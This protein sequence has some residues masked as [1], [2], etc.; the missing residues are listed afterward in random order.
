MKPLNENSSI[1][2]NNVNNITYQ[3]TQAQGG[4]FIYNNVA[5]IQKEA[6]ELR[7]RYSSESSGFGFGVSAGVGSNGQIKPNSISG[8]ISINGGNQNTA[9]TVY[10]NGNFNNVNE[11]HNNT[12]S[13]TLS[14]FNQEG[15]KVT[16]N[17]GKL[18]VESRQNTSTTTGSSSGISLGISANG[19]PNS[20]NV[21]GSR[22]NGSRAFVDN[23]SS[24]V[25][26]EGSNLHVG[27]LENTGAVIGKQSDNSTTF[28]IDNYVGK[29]IQNYDTMTTTG[30][31]MGVSLGGKPRITSVGFNQDNR[32]KEG[33]TRNT[34]V[35]NVEIQNASG[36]EINRDLGKANEITKDTHRSINVNV[37]PQVIEYISNPTK[38]KEDLEVAILEGK[39]TGETVLKSIENAVNGR[40]SS[41]IGDPERRTINEIKESIIRVKTAPE[42]N[43]IATGDLNSE[44]ILKEL[45]ISAV[46]K[47]DPDN[48]NLPPKVR[49]RVDKLAQKGEVPGIFYDKITNKI[50]VDENITDEAVIRA[51]IAREWKISE[52]LKTGKG[53]EN[54]EG[55]LK[56]TVAGELAYDDMMK[57]AREGKTGSIST[58]ELGVAVMDVNSEV[59]A[60]NVLDW[61][62]A[63]YKKRKEDLG[64]FAAGVKKDLKKLKAETGYQ[65]RKAGNNAI[66]LKEQYW[67][68][69]PK[70]ANETR[71]KIRADRSA[72]TKKKKQYDAQARE[73]KAKS[74]GRKRQIDRNL[75]AKEEKDRQKIK[76]KEQKKLAEKKRKEEQLKREQEEIAKRS[77]KQH[78][79]TRVVSEQEKEYI[80]YVLKNKDKASIF[81]GYN[82]Q[83]IGK[84]GNNYIIKETSKPIFRKDLPQQY[85][86]MDFKYPALSEIRKE[87]YQG[88]A[89]TSPGIFVVGYGVTPE[90]AK[91][92][93]DSKNKAL[94]GGAVKTG[95]GGYRAIKGGGLVAGGAATCIE[96]IGGGCGV[97]LVGLSNVGF[98]ISDGIEGIQEIGYAFSGKGN[99]LA[100]GNAITEFEQIRK[101]KNPQVKNGIKAFN[102]LKYVMGEEN[103]DYWNMT[104]AMALPYA[105]SYNSIFNSP[106]STGNS[107]PN[108]ETKTL[109]NENK[110][111]V[112]NN[113]G[114]AIIQKTPSGHISGYGRYNN[115]F[116]SGERKIT[117]S[118]GSKSSNVKAG[119]P[120]TIVKNEVTA[121]KPAVNNT[122]VITG[123][124][125][126]N[127]PPLYTPET[128]RTGGT[129]LNIEKIT[130]PSR[131][132]VEPKVVESQTYPKQ[133]AARRVTTNIEIT[134][135]KGKN[136]EIIKKID[137]NTTITI[138]KHTSDIPPAYIIDDIAKGG[139]GR[140]SGNKSY[141]ENY[142]G[143]KASNEVP[144]FANRENIHRNNST[145]NYEYKSQNNGSSGSNSGGGGSK[146]SI[147]PPVKDNSKTYTLESQDA[148]W[149]FKSEI[150]KTAVK[151]SEG[152]YTSGRNNEWNFDTKYNIPYTETGNK[153]Q[154]LVSVPT[155]NAV[156]NDYSRNYDVFYRSI[157]EKHYDRLLKSGNLPP[158][159]ETSIAED[160]RYSE[161]Y[162]GINLE[163][164]LKPGT[165]KQF[166]KIG[167]RNNE[168]KKLIKEYPNMKESFTGWKKYGYIQFK[169]E[170]DQITRNLGDGKG[171]DI[172]N[173][174]IKEINF[175]KEIIKNGK[176]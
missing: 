62:G 68:K 128:V 119:V 32:D 9:E 89:I 112:E 4:T 103:Y 2:Y 57:R 156:T 108:K 168:G 55:Q 154:G 10:A 100:T 174:N 97:A 29:D 132:L 65:L 155:Y 167:V 16:G 150:P 93:K 148:N 3:G 12:G 81:E 114:K 90:R 60:D 19:I 25:V 7:N 115:K 92:N 116:I 161:R 69:N 36:D 59:T 5:N 71:Q 118:I 35:G 73:Y 87:I 51:G 40:K 54:D 67:D 162:A 82:V 127:L 83:V 98:G 113:N 176:K 106:S 88:R 85:Q 50:F 165:D 166:E 70:K 17:I 53:K 125:I 1:T 37:E 131:N 142:G 109:I 75:K 117:P 39:A 135:S 48:P 104:S 130:Q 160:A 72:T 129:K 43:L 49:A 153:G 76:E 110:M 126:S 145:Q 23:Q 21:S 172:F 111:L 18:V 14:G 101:G 41:D 20:V 38:F 102:P 15:G 158:S 169:Q 120:S 80:E 44:K 140:T 170:G 95:I 46:E 42:M 134:G 144:P 138:E 121:F 64:Q 63:Q 147:E 6:V 86:Y 159:G 152:N 139:M 66:A 61:L 30:G 91:A 133:A 11:V 94:V 146:K 157:S 58:S 77:K 124:N 122:P 45:D 107:A 52:D 164:K 143:G 13:M 151:N 47:Y 34:V 149:N 26:G 27:T 173:Q 99:T 123:G 79:D 78:E 74:E 96:T 24:F 175:R 137:G 105:M 8:N 56:A 163:F 22:T 33:I 28:K 31:S 171:L 136:V 84:S 141:L